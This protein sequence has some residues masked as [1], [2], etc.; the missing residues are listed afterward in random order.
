MGSPYELILCCNLAGIIT[1]ASRGPVAEITIS[2]QQY[3]TSLASLA[4]KS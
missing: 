4:I 1:E 2:A 3:N